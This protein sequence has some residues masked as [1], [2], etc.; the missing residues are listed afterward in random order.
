VQDGWVSWNILAG[1]SIA[2]PGG[3]AGST[4]GTCSNSTTRSGSMGRCCPTDRAR[5]K[6]V[7]ATLLFLAALVGLEHQ[8]ARADTLLLG[9]RAPERSLDAAQKRAVQIPGELA[10][11]PT[12]RLLE[13]RPPAVFGEASL[14]A[15]ADIPS[16]PLEP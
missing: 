10:A 3:E 13:S 6:S 16:A 2:P 14:L 8:T 15:C 12:E 9:D 7:L 4:P 1:R 5:Q 11:R